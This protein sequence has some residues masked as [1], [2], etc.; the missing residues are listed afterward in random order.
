MLLRLAIG[1]AALGAIAAVLAALP[2]ERQ[3]TSAAG[4]FPSRAHNPGTSVESM[5]TVDGSR[6]Y[7]L[8]VPPSYTGVDR[9]P[10]VLAFHGL[11]ATAAELEF[12]SGLSLYSD[13]GDRGFITVY[14]EGVTSALGYQYWN[15]LEEPAPAPDDVAFVGA[16]LDKLS[17]DLCIDSSRVF[18]TGVSNGAMMAVR[19]ACSLSSRIA[20]IA[21]IAG[22]YYPPVFSDEP[23]ETCLDTR[24]VPMISVHGTADQSIPFDGG[25]G[26]GGVGYRLP[27]DNA[28]PEDDVMQAWAEHNGCD[29]TRQESSVGTNVRRITYSDC[30]D[31]AAVELYAIDGGP[32]TWPTAGVDPIDANSLLWAFFQ[33]HPLPA[34][35]AVDTDG[36]TVADKQD[37][38]NDNDGCSDAREA[39]MDEKLGGRRDAKN[40]HDYL[41][42]SHDGR[43]RIDDVLLVVQQ[44]FVDQYL[45]SPPGQPPTVNPAYRADTD[46]TL[47][48]PNA[49]NT[50]PGDGFQRS[51]DVR[52]MLQQYAHDCS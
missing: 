9:V 52:M 46:R 43:N 18:A 28:G 10:V 17:D 14:P 34:F 44:Y 39:G 32:H 11:A 27:I 20:A 2:G 47:L 29:G 5:F 33:A 35:V 31:G 13:T 36:D 16:L 4:C 50:G 21:P 7:L 1:A 15:I 24:P 30:T 25:I 26:A 49:W 38:D 40:A 19:L 22:A 48:G 41:N 12:Y 8:H 23:D 42:P 37:S 45:P 51:D 6:G 3:V